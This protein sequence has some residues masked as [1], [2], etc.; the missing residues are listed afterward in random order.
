MGRSANWWANRTL[1]GDWQV[2]IRSFQ[3][4]RP[5]GGYLVGTTSSIEFVPNRFEAL[6]GGSSWTAPLSGLESVTVGRR[7]LQLVWAT[8]AGG[9]RTL[10]T[11]RPQAVQRHLAALLD[12]PRLKEPSCW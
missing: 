3:G 12:T 11:S 5:V 2:P 8:D 9:S 6:I 4:F 7:R 10:C 1:A